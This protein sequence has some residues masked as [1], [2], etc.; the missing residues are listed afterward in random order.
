MGVA[1][2]K[3]SGGVPI[4]VASLYCTSMTERRIAGGDPSLE[5]AVELLMAELAKNPGGPP[6]PPAPPVMA[7][8]AR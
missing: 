4:R 7:P 6:Q 5:K 8:P 3:D 2:S 1:I